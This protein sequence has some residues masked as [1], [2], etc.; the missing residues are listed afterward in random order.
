[1]PGLFGLPELHLFHPSFEML[2]QVD[3]QCNKGI[4]GKPKSPA[5]YAEALLRQLHYT[6][7]YYGQESTSCSL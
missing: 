6:D 2:T 4:S 7:V 3:Q 5:I 1:M